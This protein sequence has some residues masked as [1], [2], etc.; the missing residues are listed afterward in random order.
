MALAAQTT[1]AMLLDASIYVHCQGISLKETGR[2]QFAQ[3]SSRMCAI[4]VF[5]TRQAPVTRE[6]KMSVMHQC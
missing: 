4:L 3:C 1:P 2:C 5:M 6:L